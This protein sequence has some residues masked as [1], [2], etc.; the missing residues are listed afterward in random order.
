VHATQ[1]NA[2]LDVVHI[3]SKEEGAWVD[4]LKKTL[5]KD[6]WAV[7]ASQDMALDAQ[8]KDMSMAVD[9]EI[10][11]RAAVFIENG[12]ILLSSA[13]FLF[14]AAHLRDPVVRVNE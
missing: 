6:G 3:L 1:R 8:Q 5:Q 9:M 12:V 10:A 13:V 4:G 2:T 14:V 11:R 7:V